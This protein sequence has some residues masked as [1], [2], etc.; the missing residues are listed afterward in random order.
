MIR[1]DGTSDQL[2]SVRLSETRHEMPNAA[3]FCL[4]PFPKVFGQILPEYFTCE[5]ERKWKLERPQENKTSD[6]TFFIPSKEAYTRTVNQ[7]KHHIQQGDIYEV[8][9]CIEIKAENI[10][11]H[12]LDIFLTLQS[13]AQAPYAM[14]V[15]LGETYIISVSPELFLKRKGSQ[16]A[17]KPIKGTA[18]RGITE[19]EDEELKNALA[20]SL[21]EQTE[22]VMIVDVTR[23]DFSKIA[24]RGSVRVDALFDVESYKTVHQ[25]VSTIS[26]ELKAETNFETILHAVYPI[27]SITGA[28]KRRATELIQQF[29]SFYRSYYCGT[30][31]FIEANGDFELSV[32]IRSIFFNAFTKSATIGVGS[33]ITHLCEAEQEYEECLLKAQA[34]LKALQ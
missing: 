14:L 16:L 26:C 10:H 13:F 33:A 22:N 5:E 29:E 1:F 30:M 2:L 21:K 31:G 32:I 15:K 28:P 23:N 19:L 11:Q 4:I 6:T 20:T 9:Y 34:L 18:K 3:C 24:T 12:P 27:P 8:N 7:L 25:L 17:S